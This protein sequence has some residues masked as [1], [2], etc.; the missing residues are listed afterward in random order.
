MKVRMQYRADF[1]ISLVGLIITNV[2]GIIAFWVICQSVKEINGWNY[3]ELLFMYAM[4]LLVLIPQELFFNNS[5]YLRSY[6]SEGSFIKF[7]LR[8]LNMLFYYMSELF[9]AKGLAQLTVGIVALVYASINIGIHWTIA[10]ILLLHAIIFGA[11]LIMIALMLI[12]CSTGFWIIN[13]N[14]IIQLV[15]NLRDYAR[16]PIT[17]Y[18]NVLRFIFTFIIPI[19]FVSFYPSQFFLRPDSIPVI[20]YFCPVIGIVFFMLAYWVWNKGTRSFKGTGS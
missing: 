10:R 1:F 7:Y 12:A 20:A 15:A 6:L 4:A 8:P 2:S 5:W 16:Y 19:G 14:P 17:I 13:S 3:Y 11:S 18:G 9:D